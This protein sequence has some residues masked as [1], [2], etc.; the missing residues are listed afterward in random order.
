[1]TKETQEKLAEAAYNRYCESVGGV[2]FN[3]DPLPL[4]KEFS[5][6]EKKIKQAH[7]WRDAARQV[8]QELTHL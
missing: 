3:G 2:A 1:M 4:W 6:D 8:V 5:A 7:A